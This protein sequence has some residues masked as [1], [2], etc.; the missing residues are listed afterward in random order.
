MKKLLLSLII[1]LAISQI[2]FTQQRYAGSIFDIH[3][4]SQID[5][6]PR[7]FS[8]IENALTPESFINFDDWIFS[9]DNSVQI[10]PNRYSGVSFYAPYSNTPTWLTHL[11]NYSYPNALFVGI[12]CDPNGRINS[13]D[14]LVIDFAQ[15]SKDISFRWGTSG[16]YNTGIIE[17]Y[18]GVNYQLVRSCQMLW[19]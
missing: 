1:I 4:D 7:G 15:N 11:V 8:K 19:K 17:V 13:V 2:I 18:E 6:I 9:A 16:W 10:N 3:E 5:K 12:C 14:S